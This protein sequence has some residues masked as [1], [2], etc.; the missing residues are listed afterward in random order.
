MIK[1]TEYPHRGS[2]RSWTAIN[3]GDFM[4]RVEADICRMNID[5]DCETFDDYVE[6]LASDLRQLDIDECAK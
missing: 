4:S 3:R 6:F 5:V 1:V 2:A